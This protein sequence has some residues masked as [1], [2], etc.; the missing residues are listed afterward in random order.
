MGWRPYTPYTHSSRGR[1][2][3]LRRLLPLALA[4]EPVIR[5]GP[6]CLARCMAPSAVQ[7]SSQ[8]SLA[9]VI[10]SFLRVLTPMLTERVTSCSPQCESMRL[11]AAPDALGRRL[12]CLLPGGAQ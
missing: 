8:G 11:E 5:P 2:L 1:M 3:R 9:E 4:V 7:T 10:C 6:F 12:G